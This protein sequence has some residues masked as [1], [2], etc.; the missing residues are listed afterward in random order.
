MYSVLQTSSDSK[1]MQRHVQV[2]FKAI[3]ARD[4]GQLRPGSL[5]FEFRHIITTV[6]APY[7]HSIC[8]L[9]YEGN[10]CQNRI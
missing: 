9:C 10:R 4:S 2:Y 6:K 7:L 5:Y 8:P 3:R 1:N